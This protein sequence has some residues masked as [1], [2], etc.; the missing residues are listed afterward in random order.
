MS[1]I[2]TLLC[3]TLITLYTT[4]TYAV[5]CGYT[6]TEGYLYDFSELHN[7]NDYTII[8]ST[9]TYIYKINVCDIVNESQCRAKNGIVC[10]YT[11]DPSDPNTMLQLT[12]VLATATGT[13]PIWSEDDDNIY[14]SYSNGEN[15]FNSILPTAQFKYECN[16]KPSSG[17]SAGIKPLLLPSTTPNTYIFEFQVQQAC[18]EYLDKTI[19]DST[20]AN[21]RVGPDGSRSIPG[22]SP[23]SPRSRHKG[24]F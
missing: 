1:Y 22:S 2:F 5:P 13:P 15:K 19:D 16:D 14:Q 24:M 12:A 8:D 20:A 17:T 10:Q 4:I 6:D 23:V 21:T 7:S 9:R 11:L 3:L 18:A